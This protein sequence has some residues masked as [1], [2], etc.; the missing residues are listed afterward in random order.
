M[1]VDYAQ[2][3]AAMEKSREEKEAWQRLL[4]LPE[5]GKPPIRM[6]SK[7]NLEQVLKSRTLKKKLGRFLASS[8]RWKSA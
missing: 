5:E 6:N 8:F 3:R 4:S 1:D 2:F 7:R